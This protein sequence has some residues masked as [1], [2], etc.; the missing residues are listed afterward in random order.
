MGYPIAD[1]PRQ[2]PS[3]VTAAGYL[4]Y[5]VAGLLVVNI[6]VS[7]T[8]I[9]NA[10]DFIRRTY[11]ADPNQHTILTAAKIGIGFGIAVDIILVALVVVLAVFDLRGRN[12]MR[13]TTWVIA[14]LGVLCLGC[15]AFGNVTGSALKQNT[16][17][18]QTVTVD[19]K[20]VIPSWAKDA[21]MAIDI[22]STLAL[23]AVI[24]LLALP[25]SNAFFKKPPQMVAYQGGWAQP[26]YPPVPG[27]PPTQQDPAYPPIPGQA[28]TQQDPAYPPIQPPRNPDD[29]TSPPPGGFPP[30]A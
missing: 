15:G 27:Y 8:T 13:I 22:I 18:G 23:I 21:S 4:L 20:N 29:P 12:G 1:A 10:L 30:P 6:I 7:L 2:R 16:G 5:L 14:G 11:A 3:A 19:V 24:I 26:G 28:P 17:T 9:S 25:A